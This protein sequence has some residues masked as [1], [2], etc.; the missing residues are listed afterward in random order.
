MRDHHRRTIDKL[1]ERFKDDP[2]YPALIV[3]GSIAKEREKEDSDVDVVLVASA[4]EYAQ[5]VQ[6]KNY[7]YYTTDLC[8]YPGGYVDGKVVDLA[9]LREVA[10]CGSE[11][12]RAAFAGAFVAYSRLPEIDD[13][14]KRIAVYPENEYVDKI[15]SFHALIEAL[16]W[17]V[18]EAEKREDRYLLLHA[19]SDLALYGG[20][21]ILAYN[22]ILYPYHKW[23]AWELEHAAHKPQGF[24]ALWHALLEAP[25]KRTADPFCDAVLGFTDWPKPPEGWVSRFIEDNEWNWRGRRPPIEDW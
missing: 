12:A 17:Y 6:N 19:A 2:A 20:R 24:M 5:R 4:E 25:G 13:V 8:D 9:F 10:E 18:P 21:M 11:P 16:R 7:H 1:V 3:G 22:R 23:L 14:L 15:H